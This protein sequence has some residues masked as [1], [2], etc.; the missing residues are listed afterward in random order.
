MGD[1]NPLRNQKGGDEKEFEVRD[2]KEFYPYLGY[3]RKYEA[4]QK[5][6]AERRRQRRQKRRESRRSMKSADKMDLDE[7][8]EESDEDSIDEV[9]LEDDMKALRI[10]NEAESIEP[11]METEDI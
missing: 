7:D 2:P 11:D 10:V 5:I 9:A 1:R 8:E 3:K 6:I 4:K